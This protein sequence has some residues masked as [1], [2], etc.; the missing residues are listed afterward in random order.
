MQENAKLSVGEEAWGDKLVQTGGNIGWFGDKK[1]EFVVALGAL[2]SI[3][4][5]LKPPPYNLCKK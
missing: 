3:S 4:L 1:E 5:K 2:K